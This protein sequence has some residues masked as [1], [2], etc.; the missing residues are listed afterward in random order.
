MYTLKLPPIGEGIQ[1]GEIVKWD[2]KEGDTIKKDQDIVEVMTDKITV[3]IPAPVSGKISKILVPE[4]KT[5]NIGDPIVQIDSPDESNEVTTENKPVEE[6][7]KTEQVYSVN[8]ENIPSVKATPSVRAYAR[9]KNVDILK[10]KPTGPDGRI[11]KDDIDAYLK[12]TTAQKTEV[13]KP[14]N[15]AA[16]DEI[17]NVSG[18][19]KVIFDKMTKSKQIMP[20]FTVTD[21]VETQEI[22]K[23][24]EYYAKKE[25]LSF[26]S[27]FV[28]ACTIAFKD[29]PKLNAIYNENDKNYTIK[30]A[31]NIGVAVDSPYGLTVVVIKDADK[32]D[33]FTISKEIKDLAEK[34]RNNT[35]T[36]DEVR[37]STFSIT[38]IGAIGGI[39]STP[40]INYPE[41]AILAVNSRTTAII[42]NEMKTGLYLTLACD[43]RLIDGAEAAR[44]LQRVKEILEHPMAFIGD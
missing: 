39:M 36:L 35:L 30:K 21:F 34:A 32:K 19:R 4:G 2:V 24:I 17:F 37:G 42:N 10:V 5:V 6:Q 33:L 13:K 3:R 28:K 8:N 38:N 31:Y 43:H 27:F 29:F 7:P 23:T 26:T 20:H 1:E 41:V 15:P 22:Q 18:I 40:V 16:G 14:E 25:Y 12:N 44:Y 9:S 11:T